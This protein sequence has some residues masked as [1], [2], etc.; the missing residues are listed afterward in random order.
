MLGTRAIEHLAES[1]E[2]FLPESF[3]FVMNVSQ[4]VD[5]PSYALAPGHELRR[6]T[7][8]EITIIKDTLKQLGPP[9]P[10]QYLHLW[11][12]RW[13]VQGNVEILPEP[14]WRY[15]VIAFRG[16]NITV[17]ELEN[18]FD[19]APLELE[20]GFTILN[21]VFGGQASRGV[22]WHPGRLFH[23]LQFASV[24]DTFFLDISMAEIIEVCTLRS[25][26]QKHDNR[27][28]D[29]KRLA[30]QLKDLK[31]LPHHSPL[32]FLGYF[33]ILESLLT[34][35]PKP[36]DPYDSITRQVKRKVALLDNRWTRRIDYAAFGGGSQD[37]IWSKMYAYRSQIA[38]GGGLDLTG[39]MKV[40]G[41]HQVALRLIKETAKAVIRQAL[42]EPQL[43]VD[44]REC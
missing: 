26:L 38:H 41:S 29:I 33:G 40:L 1:S 19:L 34:H 5:A 6:A 37:M 10:A 16:S 15:F 3:A 22:G 25:Q 31:A 36:S 8:D 9:P 27:L 23:V 17:S 32:R 12:C 44:L 24:D 14:E 43:L 21:G 11:E 18:A 13:P 35:A 20:V 39:E 7:N 30:A 4:L 2:T 28:V 42:S